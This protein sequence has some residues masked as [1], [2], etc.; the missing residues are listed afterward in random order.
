MWIVVYEDKNL[1]LKGR[2][3]RR[4]EQKDVSIAYGQVEQML[5]CFM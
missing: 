5:T 2:K 4:E 3:E 1:K